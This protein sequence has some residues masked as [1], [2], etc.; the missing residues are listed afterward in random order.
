ML[1]SLGIENFVLAFTRNPIIWCVAQFIGWVFV[2]LMAA[3]QNV[4]MRNN[5]PVEL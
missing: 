4:I 5:I 2:P 1:F 3:N